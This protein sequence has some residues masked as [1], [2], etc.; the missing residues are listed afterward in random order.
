MALD[1]HYKNRLIKHYPDIIL[2]DE[3]MSRHTSF[4]VG[5]PADVFIKPQTLDAALEVLTS[6]RESGVP[7]MVIGDGTNLIVTDEGIRGV[8][9]VLSGISGEISTEEI[10]ETTVSVKV[11]AGMKTHSLCRFA[12]DSGLNGMN[13][14]MGIPGT[15]GGNISMNAGTATGSME[16]VV[17]SIE[18]I[19]GAGTI[20]SIDKKELHFSYRHLEYGAEHT[21]SG[22]APVIINASFLLTK[23]NKADIQ[24]EA[25]TLLKSRNQ[26]QPVSLPNAGCIFKNPDPD[27]PAGK[28]IDMAGLK[29]KQIGGAQISKK[30]ANFIVNTGNASASDIIALLDLA[31]KEVAVKYNKILETEVK[32][33][34]A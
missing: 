30:H 33:V 14:A 28:L 11:P 7:A 1:K 9:M 6:A 23:G 21:A 17:S 24:K 22:I 34:G 4:R 5:G 2:F 12:M 16:S 3:P 19:N 32:I 29:G 25:D 8:V 15:V 13:F 26:N 31:K 20:K 27:H 18:V 10:S